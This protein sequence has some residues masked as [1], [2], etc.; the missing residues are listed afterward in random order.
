MEERLMFYQADYFPA[1]DAVHVR[2]PGDI[3]GYLKAGYVKKTPLEGGGY[4]MAKPSEAIMLFYRIDEDGEYETYEQDMRTQI[5]DLYPQW[6]A[7]SKKRVE[8][9][10]LEICK[11]KI[12]PFITLDANGK[13]CI[14]L[15]K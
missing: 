8:T 4:V 15:R 14:V 2:N 1:P 7:L 10:S 3:P 5:L 11:G 6:K 13:Q 9:V 12:H